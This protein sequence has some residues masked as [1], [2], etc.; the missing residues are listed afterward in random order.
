MKNIPIALLLLALSLPTLAQAIGLEPG[1]KIKLFIMS[2]QS[3]MV[4]QG[5]EK[6]LTPE[7]REGDP[8]VMMFEGGKWQPLKP[9]GNNKM[10]DSPSFGP[11]IGFAHRMAEAWPDETIGI[12]KQAIGGTGILAWSPTWTKEQADR[13]GDAKRGNLWKVLTGKVAA[14]QKAAPCEVVGFLW[15]QG[16]KDMKNDTGAEYLQNLKTLVTAMREKN[17]QPFLPFVLGSYRQTGMP[18]DLSAIKDQITE[19]MDKSRRWGYDVSQAQYDIQKVAPPSRMVP[20]RN[21][22]IHG[23]G[24]GHYNTAGQLELGRLFAEAYLDMTGG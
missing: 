4:G 15:M 12:V 14:A 10:V 6:K 22:P 17:E 1:K 5:E 13:T 9:A 11:E 3:N 20:L 8:R 16:S 7:L 19:R 21:L 18:D 24:N 2:G 23:N